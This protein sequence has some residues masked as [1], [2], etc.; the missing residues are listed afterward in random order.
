MTS[1][2]LWVADRQTPEA[3]SAM[4]KGRHAPNQQF[5]LDCGQIQENR[6]HIVRWAD[7]IRF[8]KQHKGRMRSSR[9][10]RSRMVRSSA[11]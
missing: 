4:T 11:A 3:N 8:T 2:S 9:P 6:V 5:V 7:N 10:A 1:L